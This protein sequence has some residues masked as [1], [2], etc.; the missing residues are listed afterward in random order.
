MSDTAT[1]DDE[2]SEKAS[3][4]CF[5]PRRSLPV[6]ARS[7][8]MMEIARNEEAMVGNHQP[9]VITPQTMMTKAATNRTRMT[10][11]CQEKDVP[12]PSDPM[13]QRSL[14]DSRSSQV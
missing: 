10:L 1:S 9:C 6:I 3:T 2:P 12:P 4:S 14:N 5:S 7:M 8:M 13:A 11:F